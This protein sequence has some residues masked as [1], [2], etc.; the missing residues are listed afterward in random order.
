MPR[1]V[2]LTFSPCIDKNITVNELLADHKLSCA[3]PELHPGGGGI[4]VAR[5][6]HRFGGDVTAVYPAGGYTGRQLKDMMNAEG[7]TSAVVDI[8]LSTH[9]NIIISE[10]SSGKQFRLGTPGTP[11]TSE[12]CEELIHKVENIEAFDFLVVSGSFP[13]G[14]NANVI[15]RLSSIATKRN[16]KF[17]VDTKGEPLKE[18]IHTGVY[19]IKPNLGELAALANVSYIEEKDIKETAAKILAAGKCEAIVVSMGERGAMLVTAD[20]A[21]RFTAPLVK[22]KSTLGAGDSMVAGIITGLMKGYSLNEAVKFGVA[23]GTATTLRDGSRLCE[24]SDA[25]DILKNISSTTC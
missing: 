7:I 12:A 24:R 16:V 9:E 22:R 1:V 11:L 14:V 17:I 23:C 21:E 19:L 8:P 15:K 13:P 6:I 18:A 4:N 25:D 2:T 5:V 20:H 10:T 3:A